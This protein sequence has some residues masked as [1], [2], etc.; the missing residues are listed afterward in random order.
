MPDRR[1]TGTSGARGTVRA[2]KWDAPDRLVGPGR[3]T[4][5]AGCLQVGTKTGRRGRVDAT[6][7]GTDATADEPRGDGFLSEEIN[8]A[9]FIEAVFEFISL[10]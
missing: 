10:G 8:E 4:G 3:R 7:R 2:G 9:R 1:R 6:P 5:A